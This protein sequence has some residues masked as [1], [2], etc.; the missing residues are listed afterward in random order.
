VTKYKYTGTTIKNQNLIHEEIKSRLNLLD[1]LL[2]FC[3]LY[4][5]IKVKICDTIVLPVVLYMCETWS[6]TL[7]EK[8]RI[9][10]FEN[11]AK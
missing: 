5:N 3:L 9:M 6:V 1:N 11:R 7:K 2:S 4:K 8:Q 10:V